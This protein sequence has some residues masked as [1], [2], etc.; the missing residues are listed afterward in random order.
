MMYYIATY[1]KNNRYAYNV[2]MH[3]PSCQ[4]YAT[5][6]SFHLNLHKFLFVE[7]YIFIFVNYIT[8]QC[9]LYNYA[10]VWFV[11]LK[12]ISVKNYEK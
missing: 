7:V 10:L 12:R 6:M 4:V 1:N 9:T 3:R 5:T 11:T 8:M 2:L